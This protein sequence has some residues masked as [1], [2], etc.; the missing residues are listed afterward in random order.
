MLFVAEPNLFI[1]DIVL[2]NILPALFPALA[3]LAI[4]LTNFIV[5]EL[6]IG[7]FR[8]DCMKLFNFTDK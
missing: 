2:E 1:G 7:A 8:K 6:I 4:A 3:R 5:D